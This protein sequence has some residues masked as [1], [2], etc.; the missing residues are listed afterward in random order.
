VHVLMGAKGIGYSGSQQMRGT[1]QLCSVIQTK[2]PA[3]TLHCTRMFMEGLSK[4]Q[5][6]QINSACD[7]GARMLGLM[8]WHINGS[9]GEVIAW[10]S[11]Q[12][13]NQGM[14]TAER[15][16]RL[17]WYNRSASGSEYHRGL[18]GLA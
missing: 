4:L 12:K 1:E 14:A 7:S 5:W 8:P 16:E 6:R 3:I 2:Q 11:L 15:F 17:R 9:F 10:K 13:Q 18:L